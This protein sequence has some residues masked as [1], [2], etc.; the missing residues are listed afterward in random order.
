M[1]VGV[2]VTITADD[3]VAAGACWEGVMAFVVEHGCAAAEPADRMVSLA[4]S[5]SVSWINRAAKLTGYGYGGGYG[6]G[7][8]DDGGGGDGDGG[9]RP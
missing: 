6:Y 8:G 9:Y 3:V 2:T 7:N 1:G 5:D 4:D